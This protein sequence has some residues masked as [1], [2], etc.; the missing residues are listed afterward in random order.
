MANIIANKYST[1]RLNG[2]IDILG[3]IR[4]HFEDQQEFG[5][6]APHKSQ[7]CNIATRPD[8]KVCKCAVGA[9]MSDRALIDEAANANAK[10]LSDQTLGEIHDNFAWNRGGGA[11]LEWAFHPPYMVNKFR[12]F[13]A[14]VQFVHDG[15]AAR[16]DGEKC[17]EDGKAAWGEYSALR[18]QQFLFALSEAEE[19]LRDMVENGYD[20]DRAKSYRP[21]LDLVMGGNMK[22]RVEELVFAALTYAEAI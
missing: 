2:I 6:E 5:L 13:L 15:F 11:A 18:L 14:A 21:E 4:R 19:T 17:K 9:L 10:Q 7:C 8:G 16:M 20:I 12:L 3:S 1:G 22:R